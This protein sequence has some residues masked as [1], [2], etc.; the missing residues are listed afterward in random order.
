MLGILSVT[1]ASIPA[2]VQAFAPD[3]ARRVALIVANLAALVAHRFLREPRLSSLI[4][5]LWTRLT[6]TARRFDRLMAQIAAN[7]APKPRAPS[8]HRPTPNTV[9]AAAPL[10]TGHAWLIRALPSEA[11][12]YAAQLESLLAEPAVADL[13]AAHPAAARILRPLGRML[14]LSALAPKRAAPPRRAATPRPPP[15]PAPG[16]ILPPQRQLAARP[17]AHPPLAPRQSRLTNRPHIA[18]NARQTAGC[19]AVLRPRV[20]TRPPPANRH[21]ILPAQ[22]SAMMSGQQPTPPRR[23]QEGTP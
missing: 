1:H 17:L 16:P 19:E 12:A 10:P 15:A 7:R 14:G 5:P 3:L 6:R 18:P 11:A 23:A 4:I 2:P 13:L 20:Q 22:N 9:R 21:F 8:P